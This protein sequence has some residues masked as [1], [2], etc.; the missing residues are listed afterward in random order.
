MR[1]QLDRRIVALEAR[2]RQSRRPCKK[3]LPDWLLAEFVAQ[4][5]R[6]EQDG[7]LDLESIRGL[8]PGGAAQPGRSAMAG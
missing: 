3:P 1:S 2:F 7:T 8:P 5:A 4:G 6:M